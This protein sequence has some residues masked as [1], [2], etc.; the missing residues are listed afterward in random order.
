MKK[1]ALKIPVLLWRRLYSELRKRSNG[2]RESGAF[3]LGSGRK[4]RKF[5]CYDDLDSHA[6]DSGII[7]IDG[8]A[9][10]TLWQQCSIHNLK[11][12]ADIHCHP[13]AWTA[14]SESDRS[15][16]AVAQN[17]H[18]AIIL[19]NFASSKRATLQGAGVFEYLGNRKWQETTIHI[20]LL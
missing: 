17:G 2:R 8:A 4:I 6:L 5:I 9:F 20:S 3:L 18:I 14:Q 10:A 16:P 19:P 1:I 7:R 12:L 11:V 15:N 13:S